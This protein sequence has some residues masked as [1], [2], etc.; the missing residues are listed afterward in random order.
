MW[1]RD[2]WDRLINSDNIMAFSVVDKN[3]G[4]K[5]KDPRWTI[6]ARPSGGYPNDRLGNPFLIEEQTDKEEAM[7]RFK[8]IQDGLQGGKPFLELD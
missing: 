8:A 2:H 4:Q 1:I 6:S 3:Q 5:G 7:I